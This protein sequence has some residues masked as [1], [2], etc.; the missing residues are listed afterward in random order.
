MTHVASFMVWCT[1]LSAGQEAE[2]GQKKPEVWMA[3]LPADVMAD[4]PSEWVYVQEHLDGLKIWTQQ[5]DLPAHQWP[6]QG[7]VEAPGALA[8]LI[9]TLNKHGIPLII[10]KGAWPPQVPHAALEQMG[11]EAGPFDATFA[12]RAAANEIDRIRRLEAMGAKVKHLDVD[13]PIRHMLHPGF[14]EGAKGFPSIDAA[15]DQFIDY[16]RRIHEVFPDITFFALTNFP[17]WGWKG[18]ISY[19]GLGENGMFWGD[20]YEVVTHL[21][22][23][24]GAARVPLQG[25]TGDNPYDYILAEAPSQNIEKAKEIDWMK[26]VRDLEDLVKARGFEYNLIVNSQRGGGESA[27]VFFKETLAFI[28]RYQAAGGRPDRYIVQSWYTHP[29]R[30]MIVP[31]DKPYTFTNLAKTVIEKVKGE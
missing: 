31:E 13:G 23:K 27:E 2:P 18:D 24:A 20:Y 4:H 5:A 25:V 29:T 1:V 8:K 26:R 28:D 11:G 16:M 12:E 17:N 3:V 9:Q 15:V 6:F 7:G 19:W 30:D 10:E 14:P 22:D 21:L